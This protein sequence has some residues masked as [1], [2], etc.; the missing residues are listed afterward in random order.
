MA[1]KP[2]LRAGVTLTTTRRLFNASLVIFDGDGSARPYLAE[3][4][5]RLGAE[6][7]RL[8]PDG[9]ME[10]TY[11]LRPNAAWHDGRPLSAEDFVFAWQLYRTPEIGLAGSPPVNI[12]E[13]TVATDDRTIVIRWRQPYAPAGLLTSEFPPLPRHVLEEPFRQSAQQGQ[14]DPLTV[15]SFW[16]RDYVGLGPFRVARWEPG[17]SIEGDAFQGHTLGVPKIPRVRLTFLTDVN[18]ALANLLSGVVHFVAD[19]AIAFQQGL[20]LKR[21]WAPQNA[22]SVLFRPD[23]WRGIYVQFRPELTR[24]RDLLD[25]RVRR[26]LTHTA[27]KQGLQEALF[28]GEGINAETLISPN[29]AFFPEVERAI[30]KYPYEPRRAGELMNEVGFARGGDGLYSSPT[31]GRFNFEIR[32]NQAAQYER[33]MSILAAGWRDVGFEVRE[34]VLPLAQQADGQARSSFPSLASVSSPLGENT[35]SSYTVAAIPRSE[36]RWN[37]INRGGW[38]HPEFQRLADTFAVT[39]EPDQRTRLVV[40]MARLFSE[41]TPLISLYFELVPAAYTAGLQGPQVGSPEGSVA[42]NV[43]EWEFR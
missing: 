27:D 31:E 43:H 21:Q 19:D 9:R 12:I 35:L 18:T 6:D 1:D 8:F 36:N 4:L 28:E 14:F 17:A 5:P 26:A 2:L 34:S 32:V 25:V 33:E 22:G 39:L 24:P 20:A 40:Q 23:R 3:A 13:E 16:S 15:H 41:E 29:A 38:S 42:W 37:G 10:T 30:V 11:R 7:W